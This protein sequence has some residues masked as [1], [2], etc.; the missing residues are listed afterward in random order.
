MRF[1]V[2]GAA[3]FIGSHLA[4]E[5]GARGHDVV[6]VDCLTDYYDPAEKEENFGLLNHGSEPR[7]SFAAFEAGMLAG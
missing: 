2:T 5:L 6:G 7:L 4:E 1:C 3:G